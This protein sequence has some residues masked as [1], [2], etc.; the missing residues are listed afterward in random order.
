MDE[1][2]RSLLVL[3]KLDLELEKLR[4]RREEI[5]RQIQNLRNQVQALEQERQDFL[6][7]LK[8]DTVRLKEMYLELEDLEGTL[9]K[10]QTQL[11]EIKSN[12]EYRAM[13]AQIAQTREQIREL[14]DRILA[15][16]EELEAKKARKPAFEQEIATR[17]AA[18][19]QEIEALEAELQGIPEKEEAL[20]VERDQA[21]RHVDPSYLR[22]Y[23]R[24]RQIRGGE[25]V[26][27]VLNGA[28]GG[29]H[30]ALPM[31]VV[32]EVRA[33]MVRTCENCGRLLYWSLERSQEAGEGAAG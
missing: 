17:K 25:V 26:V 12:E 23:R 30:A 20:S 18:L 10:Y 11:F 29:C 32:L 6:E 19:E 33:G 2:L 21:E 27:P 28:C 16:E 13:Q 8:Q 22:V 4:R 3:Q 1:K 24:L 14:E 5:P 15:F 9:Q 31:Q 7:G